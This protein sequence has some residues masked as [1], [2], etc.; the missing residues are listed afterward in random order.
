MDRTRIPDK[1]CRFD[2]SSVQPM[3]PYKRKWSAPK[4]TIDL[5]LDENLRR[6]VRD[7]PRKINGIAWAERTVPLS[8]WRSIKTTRA[9]RRL[10][11]YKEVREYLEKEHLGLASGFNTTAHQ[12]AS[13]LLAS[14]SAGSLVCERRDAE[15]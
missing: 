7:I 1:G 2:H 6:P 8:L 10:H 4:R 3:N 13:R 5:R 14:E 9:R 12:C 11:N 15:L